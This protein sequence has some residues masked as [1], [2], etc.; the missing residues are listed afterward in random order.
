M[1]KSLVVAVIAGCL[2]Q[3]AN[4]GPFSER[5]KRLFA[6]DPCKITPKT[7]PAALHINGVLIG[8]FEEVTSQASDQ[9]GAQ[10]VFRKGV[11]ASGSIVKFWQAQGEIVDI[12]I[13][14]FKEGV[15]IAEGH[16]STVNQLDA[17]SP[18]E[19]PSCLIV[20]ELVLDVEELVPVSGT[21]TL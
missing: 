1:K 10:V 21:L 4:A 5:L 2:V 15:Y 17:T 20:K 16:A 18:E 14:D 3:S 7:M 11:I 9:G 13:A 8:A 19:K 12:M 6:E